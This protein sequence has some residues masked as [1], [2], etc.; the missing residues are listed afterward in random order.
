MTRF[1]KR[2]INKNDTILRACPK[3]TNRASDAAIR[4][5]QAHNNK[6]SGNCWVL[7]APLQRNIDLWCLPEWISNKKHIK[8][9]K[10]V[11]SGM[12]RYERLSYDHVATEMCDF[13]RTSAANA[14]SSSST[15]RF[16][17]ASTSWILIDVR[18]GI[19]G[20]WRS[21]TSSWVTK[22]ELMTQEKSNKTIVKISQ[23]V[24]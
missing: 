10:D 20:C 11:R 2:S 18:N 8:I 12:A 21:Q 19:L 17:V 3:W 14:G 15:F 9:L 4:N 13:W 23:V 5:E 1:I 16:Q 22:L 24:Q 6:C 7:E